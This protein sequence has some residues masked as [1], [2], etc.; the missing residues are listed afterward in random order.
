MGFPPRHR[1]LVEKHC[2]ATLVNGFH[3]SGAMRMEYEALGA[4]RTVLGSKEAGGFA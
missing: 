1:A 4:T 2:V 3:C